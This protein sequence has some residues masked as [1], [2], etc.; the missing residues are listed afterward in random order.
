MSAFDRNRVERI[1]PTV[2]QH[3]EADDVGG[4]A[5][6]VECGDDVRVGVA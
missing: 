4:V 6:L 1:G 3:V 2:A 5:W